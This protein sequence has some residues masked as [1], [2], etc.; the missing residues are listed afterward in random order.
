MQPRYTRILNLIKTLDWAKRGVTNFK[1][2]DRHNSKT[3]FLKS[4]KILKWIYEK[5][6]MDLFDPSQNYLYV[7]NGKY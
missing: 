4:Q 6:I 5:L 2:T 3:T 1:K 7:S